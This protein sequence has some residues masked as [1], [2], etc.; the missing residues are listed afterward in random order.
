MQDLS[1]VKS[2]KTFALPNEYNTT[3][4][5]FFANC[6]CIFSLQHIRLLPIIRDV[7]ACIILLGIYRNRT[8]CVLPFCYI[9]D[10]LYHDV[11]GCTALYYVIMKAVVEKLREGFYMG[12]NSLIIA[13]IY[14]C[15][16][17]VT[18]LV[19]IVKSFVY[20]NT[21][22]VSHISVLSH[23]QVSF[24]VYIIFCF[25]TYFVSNGTLRK[26]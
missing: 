15:G 19:A 11:I 2:K 12:K 3:I 13:S 24:A 18:Y 14:M 1:T 20:G 10:A 21:G 26:N 23:V 7:N 4:L 8:K 5:L 22:V 25:V 17:I 16:V 9:I 6:I